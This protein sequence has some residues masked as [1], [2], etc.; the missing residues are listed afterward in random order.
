MD[1]ISKLV[2]VLMFLGTMTFVMETILE[3]FLLDRIPKV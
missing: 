2:Q 1:V 3:H